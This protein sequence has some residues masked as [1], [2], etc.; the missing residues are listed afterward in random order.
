LQIK[1]VID[2]SVDARISGALAEIFTDLIDIKKDAPSISDFE[3]I[4]IANKSES[5]IL[6]EDKDFG[7]W[8]FSHKAQVLGTILLRYHHTEISDII[9]SLLGI[10][11]RKDSE[12]LS[13]FIVITPKRIRI[14]DI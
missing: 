5:V 6:T 2:E 10:L 3:V 13:K 12:I 4:E 11:K 9:H 8:V 1:L 14:R 7:E